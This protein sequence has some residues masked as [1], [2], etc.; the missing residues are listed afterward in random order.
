MLT[1]AWANVAKLGAGAALLG[2]TLWGIRVMNARAKRRT[3][4]AVGKVVIFLDIDGV[5][6]RTRKA[7]Q[8]V[9]EPGLVRKLRRIIESCPGGCQIIL[10][11]FWRPF[12][13]YIAYAL[14]R[15]GGINASLVVGATPGRSKSTTIQLSSA[16][17]L[18]HAEAF[19]DMH[20]YQTRAAEIRMFLRRNPQVER[21]VILD[22]R[23]D[24]ADD[25]LLDRFVKTDPKLGLT[26]D[27]VECAIRTLAL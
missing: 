9:L 13:D 6:N 17:H 20:V 1:M 21:F 14:S 5:L 11:T 3:I 10:S 7:D 19:D 22:D 23:A 12:D 26:D 25:E 15:V 16:R 18:L 2:A 4:P 27:D 24:A 8:V